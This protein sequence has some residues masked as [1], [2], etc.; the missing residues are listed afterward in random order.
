M[1]KLPDDQPISKLTV[2]VNCHHNIAI[3][4]LAFVF[5][6][7]D[8]KFGWRYCLWTAWSTIA[9]QTHSSSNITRTSSLLVRT[10][11]N[12]K[13]ARIPFPIYMCPC[14]PERKFKILSQCKQYIDIFIKSKQRTKSRSMVN[15]L[16]LPLEHSLLYLI[17]F[18]C[19][20]FTVLL[21]TAVYLF[22]VKFHFVKSTNSLPWSRFKVLDQNSLFWPKFTEGLNSLSQI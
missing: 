18:P 22:K 17:S 6:I 1:G 21:G 7:I 13:L 16:I 12:R 9:G 10:G 8:S 2:L 14:W 4:D 15:V 11:I 3:L 19:P 5:Q 20:K